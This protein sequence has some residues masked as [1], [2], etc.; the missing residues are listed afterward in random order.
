MSTPMIVAGAQPVSELGAV[1]SEVVSSI[2][3]KYRDAPGTRHGLAMTLSQ[4]TGSTRDDDDPAAMSKSSFGRITAPAG[5][6]RSPG[7]SRST[8][9]PRARSTRLRAPSRTVTRG[10]SLPVEHARKWPISSRKSWFRLESFGFD[11]VL[12][13]I[14]YPVEHSQA[15]LA[16]VDN[17]LAGVADHLAGAAGGRCM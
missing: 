16:Q 11:D 6:G 3:R 7:L 2:V 9:L 14:S 13:D 10:V 12:R 8:A 1:R 5:S 15:E 17:D 4:K